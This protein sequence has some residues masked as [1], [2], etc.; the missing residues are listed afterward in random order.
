MSAAAVGPVGLWATRSVVQQVH[1][2]RRR[3]GSGGGSDRCL[4]VREVAVGPV[5]G[6][7]ARAVED[8]E[9]AVLVDV[10]PHLHLDEVVPVPVRRDLQAAALVAHAVVVADHALDLH[11]QDLGQVAGVGHE[12]AAGLGRRDAKRA[13]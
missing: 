13:L 3:A 5:A 10:H 12:R 1:R 2:A 11:A 8:R 9:P 4:D 7:A 6:Q